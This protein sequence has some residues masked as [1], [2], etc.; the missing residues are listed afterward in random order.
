M[1]SARMQKS[2]KK[3]TLFR[4]YLGDFSIGKIKKPV[5]YYLD[6]TGLFKS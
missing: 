3:T 2:N 5:P 1:R 4:R 6:E